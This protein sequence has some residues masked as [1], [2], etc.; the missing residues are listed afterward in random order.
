MIHIYKDRK[1]LW[2]TLFPK[3]K[4]GYICCILVHILLGKQLIQLSQEAPLVVV[5]GH[6]LREFISCLV[7]Q[8]TTTS[9]TSSST[10]S[11]SS[12][13]S[14][15]YLQMSDNAEALRPLQATG[16]GGDE[17]VR[18][19]DQQVTCGGIAAAF[20]AN[21]PKLRQQSPNGTPQGCRKGKVLSV[22]W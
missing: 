19:A 1:L 18:A 14:F 11:S 5:D 9:N 22:R 2:F 6:K 12:S 16:G 10:T 15:S 17:F 3:T 7:L 20:R 4:K 13:I 8:I 21:I